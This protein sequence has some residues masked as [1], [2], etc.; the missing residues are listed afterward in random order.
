MKKMPIPSHID[1]QI[2]EIAHELTLGGED[3]NY[4]AA[5]MIVPTV[6][7]LKEFLDRHGLHEFLHLVD[8]YYQTFDSALLKEIVVV[9]MSEAI[10]EPLVKGAL[11]L[12]QR[13]VDTLVTISMRHIIRVL[14]NITEWVRKSPKGKII[15]YQNL[16]MGGLY[17]PM[18]RDLQGLLAAN[19][20]PVYEVDLDRLALEGMSSREIVDLV[21]PIRK[22]EEFQR[23]AI[24]LTRFK[25]SS[26]PD[27]AD[28]SHPEDFNSY[29]SQENK[30]VALYALANLTIAKGEQSRLEHPIIMLDASKNA[31]SLAQ[32]AVKIPL[33]QFSNALDLMSMP[34]FYH[35][36]YWIAAYGLNN[37]E[38]L[39]PAGS[40]HRRAGK[41]YQLFARKVAEV[42]TEEY[43]GHVPEPEI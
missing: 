33:M 22:S 17:P 20:Y 4:P 2:R 31:L 24:L 14:T 19:G 32:K 27:P 25:I 5:V 35:H 1:R 7:K 23:A 21:Q 26:A 13:H 39:L 29:A 12:D 6:L 11:K 28:S 10:N 15:L 38:D 40:P 41:F 34:F 37:L 30:L 36:L 43:A 8:H 3:E 9:L 16:R 18:E 42:L